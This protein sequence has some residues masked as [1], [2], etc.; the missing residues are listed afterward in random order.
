MFLDDRGHVR[1]AVPSPYCDFS[2]ALAWFETH[3]DGV[4][5]DM[6]ATLAQWVNRKAEYARVALSEADAAALKRFDEV[7]GGNIAAFSLRK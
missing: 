4:P 5:V 7:Y 3:R 6:F 2:G 1:F